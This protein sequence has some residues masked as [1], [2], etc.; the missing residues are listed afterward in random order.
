MGRRRGQGISDGVS[1]DDSGAEL[2]LNPF[3][4]G[5]KDRG[6]VDREWRTDGRCKAEEA[7]TEE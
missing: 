4:G 1:E 6:M 5:A 2:A 3:Y 7:G